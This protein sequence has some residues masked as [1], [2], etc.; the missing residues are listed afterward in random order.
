MWLGHGVLLLSTPQQGH[1]GAAT[2]T[3]ARK[4]PGGTR[5]CA[6]HRCSG[7]V[8]SDAQSL[9]SHKFFRG[10]CPPW[11]VTPLVFLSGDLP[12]C[13]C[14][15]RVQQAGEADA[16]GSRSPGGAGSYAT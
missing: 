6:L 7:C 13:R 1:P 3:P 15:R 4:V 10:R 12:P 9:L 5:L 11:Q 14:A 2:A 8:N 16:Q